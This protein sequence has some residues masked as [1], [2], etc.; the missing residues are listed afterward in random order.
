MKARSIIL[1]SNTNNFV[2][3]LV[4]EL[5]TYPSIRFFNK[6]INGENTI[7]I[8]CFNY[9]DI[10]KEENE[11]NFYGNYIYLYTCL[12]LILTDLIIINYENIFIKRILHYNYF[13]FEKSKLKKISNIITLILNPNSPLEN[14]HELLLFR[15]QVILAS[16]LKN[17]HK[18]NYMHIDGFI[19]FGLTSYYEFLEEIVFN[20]VQLSISNFISIEK[21]NF[22]IKNMFDY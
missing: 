12:S 11:K 16:L 18:T 4:D 13:Y 10:K 21:L 2:K 17:F 1:K 19:N 9:Y 5:L 22:V 7:V 15:K 3:Q 8:K 14:S 6:K 20:I